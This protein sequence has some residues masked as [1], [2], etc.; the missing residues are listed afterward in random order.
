MILDKY[1]SLTFSKEF[2][3]MKDFE[4]EDKIRFV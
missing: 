4:D 1:Q 3:T 2:L